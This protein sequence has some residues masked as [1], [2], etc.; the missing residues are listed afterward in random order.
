MK[1][2]FLFIFVFTFLLGYPQSMRAQ[3]ARYLRVTTSNIP[4]RTR[5][6]AKAPCITEYVRHGYEYKKRTNKGEIV[7]NLGK[8]RNGYIYICRACHL[9]V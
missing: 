3:T 5:P 9:V 1:K 8:H 4:V 7:K 2:Y 6:S